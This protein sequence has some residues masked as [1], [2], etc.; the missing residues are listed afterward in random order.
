MAGLDIWLGQATRGLSKDSTARVRSE[1]QEHYE[2]A[3]ESALSGGSTV[4][5]A[6]RMALAAL[7][8]ATV[9]NRQYRRVLLTSSEARMLREGNSEARLVCSLKWA[10][11]IIPIAALV[12]A[13]A[14]FSAGATALARVL[15]VA[16][17]GMGVVFMAPFLPIYTPSRGRVFRFVKWVAQLAV[18]GVVFKLS[19]LFFACFWALAWVE[20]TRVSIRRKLPVTAWPKQLYL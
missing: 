7:G 6:D 19:W 14:F 15:L 3:R 4:D 1:I 10:R 11:L 17:V 12:A 9:A 5:E 8:D 2:S 18:L 13:A 20:W 16:G